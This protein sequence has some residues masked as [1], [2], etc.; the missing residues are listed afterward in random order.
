LKPA[1]EYLAEL[2]ALLGIGFLWFLLLCW[3]F[4]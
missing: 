2:A 1:L 4:L 3:L